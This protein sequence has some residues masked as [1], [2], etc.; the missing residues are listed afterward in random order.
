MPNSFRA[1]ERAFVHQCAKSQ[2][3]LSKSRGK[4]G[5]RAVTIFKEGSLNYLKN[6][7]KI[8]LTAN[9]RK[10]VIMSVTQHA[11][12]RQ[13]K[14]DLLPTSERDRLRGKSG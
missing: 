1:S 11:L 2:G 7:S 5:N 4:G 12:T 13:E 10:A 3:L 9:S 14:Q 8:E 6:D